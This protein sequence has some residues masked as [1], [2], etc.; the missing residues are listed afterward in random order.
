MLALVC[1]ALSRGLRHQKIFFASKITWKVSATENCFHLQ[2]MK[3]QNVVYIPFFL[4]GGIVC[5]PHLLYRVPQAA[6]GTRVESQ[7]FL[8]EHFLRILVFSNISLASRMLL[9]CK[10]DLGSYDGVIKY[11]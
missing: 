9:R 6:R 5:G 4:A 2:L 1:S 7:V 11:A 3:P 8:R 10:R